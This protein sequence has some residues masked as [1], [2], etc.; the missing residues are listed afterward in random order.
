MTNKNMNAGGAHEVCVTS[1][2][3]VA[4]P[5]AAWI[6]FNK[7]TKFNRLS[8]ENH[9]SF[10]VKETEAALSLLVALTSFWD[11][12]ERQ[13]LFVA[14]WRA[15]VTN[16][17]SLASMTWKWNY[18]LNRYI[19]FRTFNRTGLAQNN[20]GRYSAQKTFSFEESSFLDALQKAKKK[21]EK[22]T[23]L[24]VTNLASHNYLINTVKGGCKQIIKQKMTIER[25][26]WIINRLP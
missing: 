4:A 16:Q 23:R 19:T 21:R 7:A 5:A 20:G 14:F 24:Y 25:F 13:K 22:K 15:K 26:G 6:A 10:H 2:G 17:L 12:D 18:D 1:N 11:M 3:A 9:L 8:F